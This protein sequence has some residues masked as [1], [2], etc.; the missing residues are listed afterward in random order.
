MNV[1]GHQH[2]GVKRKAVTFTV[3]FDAFKV[4]YPVLVVAKNVVPL[5][6]PNND[7]IKGSR[8]LHEYSDEIGTDS[9]AKWHLFRRKTAVR[10]VGAKRRWE[11]VH[12]LR[13]VLVASRLI[14]SWFF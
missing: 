5:I 11:F 12:S 14:I 2:V 10:G 7:V 3:V 13:V 6:A 8:E 4:R 1:I 9:E